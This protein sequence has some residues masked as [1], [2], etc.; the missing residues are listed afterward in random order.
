MSQKISSSGFSM[1]KMF[2]KLSTWKGSAFSYA[3]RVL[4]VRFIFQSMTYHSTKMYSWFV[5]LPRNNDQE[6]RNFIWSGNVNSRKLVTVSWK[7]FVI[8]ESMVVQV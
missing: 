7:K 2:G 5:Y 1:D 6:S 8:L 3:G 4:T